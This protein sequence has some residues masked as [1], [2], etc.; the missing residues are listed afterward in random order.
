MNRLCSSLKAAVKNLYTS[1]INVYIVSGIGS[2]IFLQL[3]NYRENRNIKNSQF[4][5]CFHIFLV[6]FLA[7][8]LEY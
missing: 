7:S 8:S 4:S 6:G 2:E 1:S 5:L 3:P